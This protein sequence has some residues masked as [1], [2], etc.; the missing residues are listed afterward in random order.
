VHYCLGANLARL[1]LS[2]ALGFL[3]ER[4]PKLEL[5][6]EPVYESITGIYG[7]AQLPVSFGA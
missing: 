7:L 2:E 5:R 3:A 1:E 4:V 6:G